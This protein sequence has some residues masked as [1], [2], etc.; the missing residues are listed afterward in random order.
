AA[1]LLE[2]PLRRDPVDRGAKIDTG[3]R[4]GRA[5]ADAVFKADDDR[6]AVIG[7]FEA[8]GGDA[9]DAG[10]PALARRPDQRARRTAMLGLGH[11][12]GT[13]PRLDLA[14]LGVERIELT[15]QPLGLDRV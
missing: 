14:P 1:T 6:G 12:F 9:D 3:D 8:G 2:K 10:V 13:H 7:L 4:P 5:L 15:R 11:G